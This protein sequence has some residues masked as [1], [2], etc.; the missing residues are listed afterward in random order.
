MGPKM[1]K[2][3]NDCKCCRNYRQIRNL[4]AGYGRL[5]L[6]DVV[7]RWMHARAVQLSTGSHRM[8]GSASGTR[9]IITSPGGLESRVGR[10]I[11]KLKPILPGTIVWYESPCKTCIR[12]AKIVCHKEGN[13]YDLVLVRPASD[14]PNRFVAI[15]NTIPD[16]DRKR[17]SI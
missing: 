11:P 4:R 13:K 9:L 5:D 1:T 8:P 16:V 14:D 10:T 3:D 2:H 12:R 6:S 7:G 15:G 17:L